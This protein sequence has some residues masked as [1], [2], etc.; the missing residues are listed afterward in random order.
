MRT[1][2]ESYDDSLMFEAGRRS[3]A[4]ELRRARRRSAIA[5]FVALAAVGHSFIGG[6]DSN[7]SVGAR[8]V[9][10][11]TYASDSK[12][13]PSERSIDDQEYFLK[14]S[15]GKPDVT[16]S[17]FHVG[18]SKSSYLLDKI[19]NEYDF[20]STNRP[21]PTRSTSSATITSSISLSTYYRTLGIPRSM[22]PDLPWR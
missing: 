2:D 6:A 9:G 22:N 7:R 17:T 19:S 1:R 3:T 5:A 21:A 18:S 8:E 4:D 20:E 16:A 13:T 11:A 12:S 10:P 14:R 15:N